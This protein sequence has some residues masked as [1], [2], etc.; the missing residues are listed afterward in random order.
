MDLLHIVVVLVV[1]GVLLWLVQTY[2]PMAAPFKTLITVVVVLFVCV[3][4]LSLF[5]IG[6]VFIGHR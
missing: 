4:L 2:I 5:G 6:S 3:W 1:I